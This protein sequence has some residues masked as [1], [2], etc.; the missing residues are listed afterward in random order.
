MK[1]TLGCPSGS[2]SA[3][4]A[5]APG[6]SQASAQIVQT[7]LD[8]GVGIQE[9]D[10]SRFNA[11]KAL[12]RRGGKAPIGR[13]RD[14]AHA[15]AGEPPST[16]PSEEALSTTTTPRRVPRAASRKCPISDSANY[17]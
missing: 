13:I 2:T 9:Q 14:Q 16:V 12:I 4:G 5:A 8:H 15:A 11:R 7:G 3:A 10:I 1:P 6:R 17:R